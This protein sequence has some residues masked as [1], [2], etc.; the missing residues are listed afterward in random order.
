MADAQ[1]LDPSVWDQDGD[2][3]VIEIDDGLDVDEETKKTPVVEL[4]DLRVSCGAVSLPFP[5]IVD[6]EK[7]R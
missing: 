2:D 6:K 4:W 3:I 7:A 5:K 1:M